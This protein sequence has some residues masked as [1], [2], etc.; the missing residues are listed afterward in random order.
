MVPCSYDHLRHL[1]ETLAFFK[2]EMLQKFVD[3]KTSVYRIALKA[4][5][6]QWKTKEYV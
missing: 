5:Q 3:V 2:F 4:V 1:M 6:I